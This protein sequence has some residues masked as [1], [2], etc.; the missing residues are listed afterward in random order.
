ML[1]IGTPVIWWGGVLALL[2]A[3]AL[4]WGR[5]DWRA[6]LAVVGALATWLPW[7]QYDDR[8]IFSYYAS[9]SLPFLVLAVTLLVGGIAGRD[10][11]RRLLAGGV[12]GV[13]LALTVVAFVFFWPVWTDGLLTNGEWLQRM[14]FR[15]WI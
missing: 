1:L 6:Q 7:L 9:A 2:G 12:A 14:W 11:R 10:R 15:R 4:W 5:R 8:P 3:V 13:V